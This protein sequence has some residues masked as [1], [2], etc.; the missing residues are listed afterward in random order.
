MNDIIEFKSELNNSEKMKVRKAQKHLP[1]ADTKQAELSQSA[2]SGAK[3][4]A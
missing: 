2:E 4:G 3:I 1:K